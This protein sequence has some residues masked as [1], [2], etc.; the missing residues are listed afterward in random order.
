M[1]GGRSERTVGK[2]GVTTTA[3]MLLALLAV[4]VVMPVV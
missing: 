2:A 1:P 3:A 4:L